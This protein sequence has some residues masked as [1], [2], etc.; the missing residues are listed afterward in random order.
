ME[1]EKLTAEDCKRLSVP[2]YY[3]VVDAI[4]WSL[5]SDVK[6]KLKEL[7]VANRFVGEYTSVF[8]DKRAHEIFRES[9]DGVRYGEDEIAARVFLGMKEWIDEIDEKR[10]W[11]CR[12]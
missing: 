9:R 5:R 1:R 2:D 7:G 12:G 3:K 4:A 6:D 10:E 11:I 8:V